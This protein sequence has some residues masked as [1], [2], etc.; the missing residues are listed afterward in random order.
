MRRPD[1]MMPWLA[2]LLEEVQLLL[3]LVP[4]GLGLERLR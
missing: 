2:V 3:L 1:E 4:A